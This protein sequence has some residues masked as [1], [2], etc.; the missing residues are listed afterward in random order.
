MDAEEEKLR[1]LNRQLNDA[2]RHRHSDGPLPD[3][4]IMKT[5]HLN[6]QINL[7]NPN[8]G[9]GEKIIASVA[10]IHLGNWLRLPS[11]GALTSAQEKALLVLIEYASSPAPYIAGSAAHSLGMLKR[12]E[13]I[14]ALQ[15]I[16][17]CD[18]Y[19]EEPHEGMEIWGVAFRAL[20]RIDR[21]AVRP[22]LHSRASLEYLQGIEKWSDNRRAKGGSSDLLRELVEES[23]WVRGELRM[24]DSA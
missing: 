14:P 23:A 16:I 17:Q 7:Q 22:F 15:R 5:L 12:R 21:E 10:L 4:S 18:D 13:G 24:G 19:V 11:T 6:H 1:S 20:M 3:E 8:L 9:R 2:I